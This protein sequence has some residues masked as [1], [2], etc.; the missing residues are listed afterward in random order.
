MD[1]ELNWK[2]VRCATEGGVRTVLRSA[3]HAAS[4][5][6]LWNEQELELREGMEPRLVATRY[7]CA[8]QEHR[9]TNEGALLASLE[10]PVE[11]PG[12]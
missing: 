2:D 11:T 4:G 10:Q 9:Y 5:V 6:R 7:W 12:A 1:S 8:D 3:V